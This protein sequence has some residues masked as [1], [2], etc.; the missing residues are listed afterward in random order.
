MDE[1]KT[2]CSLEI[3]SCEKQFNSSY[4]MDCFCFIFIN[5]KV[6]KNK[7]VVLLMG[8]EPAVITSRLK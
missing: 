2:H 4:S 6:E 8:F 5:I 3:F 7:L 1:R